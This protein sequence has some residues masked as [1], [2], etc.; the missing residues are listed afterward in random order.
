MALKYKKPKTINAVSITLLFVLGAA[1]YF[2]IYAWP[3]YS[4]SSRAKGV[5]L[6]SLPTL[7]R[8]NLLSEGAALT[9]INSLKKDVPVA[10]RKAGVKDPNLKLVF[11]RNKKEVSI[12]AQ[13]TASAFFPGIDKTIEFNLSPRAVT[14]AARVEW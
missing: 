1:V 10:L 3:V 7:W 6:D 9:M 5:L 11:S 13:F 4:L 14:D 12:E 2:I 8:A